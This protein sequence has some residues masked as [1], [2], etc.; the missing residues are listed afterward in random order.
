MYNN[1]KNHLNVKINE[2]NVVINE[3]IGD[4]LKKLFSSDDKKKEANSFFGFLGTFWSTITN[5]ENDKLADALKSIEE[6]EAKAAEENEKNLAKAEEDAYIKKL[7]ADS[8]QRKNQNKLAT[9]KRIKAYN[10]RARQFKDEVNRWKNNELEYTPEQLQAAN[11]ARDRALQSIGDVG[12]PEISELNSLALVIST[13]EDGTTRTKEEIQALRDKT[14]P[15]P[16]EK[17]L[18]EQITRFDE[19]A[20]KYE[21][22]MIDAIGSKEFA[23]AHHTAVVSGNDVKTLQDTYDIAKEAYDQ[24]QKDV[25]ET[26]KYL[27]LKSKVEEKQKVLENVDKELDSFKDIGVTTDENGDV[28]VSDSAIPEVLAKWSSD[29]DINKELKSDSSESIENDTEIDKAFEKYCKKLKDKG[30]PKEVIDKLKEKL[31][32]KKPTKENITTAWN[33]VGTDLGDDNNAE[34]NSQIKEAITTSVKE[35]VKALNDKR[36][37]VESDIETAKA[38]VKTYIDSLPENSRLRKA[39][40]TDSETLKEFIEENDPTTER[41]KENK[42]AIEKDYKDLQKQVDEINKKRK[43]RAEAAKTAA[44]KLDSHEKKSIPSEFKDEVEN[45][46]KGIEPGEE[47]ATIDGKTVV[48]FYERDENGEIKKDSNGK[49]IFHKKPGPNSSSKEVDEYI[50]KRNNNILLIE[51]DGDSK[52]DIVQNDDGTIT[53][54]YP[55]GEKI[56]FE[57]GENGEFSESDK[58]EIIKQFAN[59][60]IRSEQTSGIIAAKQEF[61][62]EIGKLIDKDG[63]FDK[64]EFDKL[65]AHKKK[66]IKSFIADEDNI[67]KLFKGVDLSGSGTYDS[68]NDIM[69]AIGEIDD[70]NVDDYDDVDNEEEGADGDDIETDDEE[71]GTLGNE[72]VVKV[73]DKWYKKS[74]VTDGVPNENAEEIS[75]DEVNNITKAKKTIENPAKKWKRRKNKN[76]GKLTRSYYKVG[77]N[78]DESISAKEFR[79]RMR[80][81][82]E[83]RKTRNESLKDTTPFTKFLFESIDNTTNKY[84]KLR[85]CILSNMNN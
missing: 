43:Q 20:K 27:E 2:S 85:D 80:K 10:A 34:E 62:D 61:A 81:Y 66:L 6:K 21:K 42:E 54:T 1:L 52:E 75:G 71:N 60:R 18:L 74:D 59:K 69:D 40:E 29:E 16:E 47:I 5:K 41:G 11:D 50:E 76:T 31:G 25:E 33:D 12:L 53:Y 9:Q 36:S 22:P 70:I 67:K 17:K 35:H 8:E 39:S 84:S 68:I 15:T 37:T 82:N 83:K 73:G 28:S 64:E 46:T 30:V 48:G 55:D 32:T 65:P 57:K 49:E 24:Y 7:E 13:K 72:K 4:V 45:K 38:D 58:A 77:G 78:N 79:D 44:A 63:K 14:N 56:T 23:D 51:T 26:S 19:L 3:A